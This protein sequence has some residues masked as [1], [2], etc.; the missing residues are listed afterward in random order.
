[1]STGRGPPEAM[2]P[3]SAGGLEGPLVSENPDFRKELFFQKKSVRS[4]WLS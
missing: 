2:A 4:G 1:M 3:S